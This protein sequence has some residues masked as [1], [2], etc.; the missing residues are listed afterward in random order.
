M[1]RSPFLRNS[2]LSSSGCDPPKSTVEWL[3][4]P[5]AARV[6]GFWRWTVSSLYTV[7]SAAVILAFVMGIQ[8]RIFLAVAGVCGL[9]HMTMVIL[10]FVPINVKARV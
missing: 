7:A 9:L 1:G 5:Y 6:F 10:I 3:A 8:T 2:S 4:T